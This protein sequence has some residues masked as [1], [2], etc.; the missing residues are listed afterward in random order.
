M[1]F[2]SILVPFFATVLQFSFSCAAPTP[3]E[4]GIDL[5]QRDS[6]LN[7][8]NDLN[9]VASGVASG[10]VVDNLL[11]D[12]KL[13]TATAAPTSPQQ[14]ISTLSH[15]LEA[16]PTPSNIYAF[17][18]NL[19]AAG[20]TTENVNSVVGFVDGLLTGDNSETNVDLAI[21]SIPVLPKADFRD[22]PYSQSEAQLRGAIHIP[23][24]FQYGRAGA[25]QPII[26][27]PGTGNTG[28][29]NFVGNYIPLLQNSKI[30]DPVWLN[31]PG[32]Q[33][34]DA[35]VNAE[36]VAYAINYIYGI[37]RQRKIAVL[38]WSQGGLSAQWANKYWPSTRS[39]ITDIVAFSP[40]YHGTIFAN[41]AATPDI[42]LPPAFLSQEYNSNFI[43]TLRS[44]GG[45]SA[46]VTTTTIYSGFFD[47]IVE[48]QQGTAASAYLLDARQV[49]VTNNEVQTICPGQ[50]AGS[51]YTHEGTLYNPIGY[52]LLVD[53]LSHDGPGQVSR[54]DL[55]SIC[56]QYL[57][58]GLDLSDLLLTE[59][60]ILTAAVTTLLYP[61][62][63]TVEPAIKAYAK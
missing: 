57:T 52:A 20:L 56:G 23:S 38:T 47:E 19:V 60:S 40:D 24:S 28:Y 2:V 25:P 31:I 42:P 58:S 43:K 11:E 45:D 14:A 5:Q 8:L 44:N 3:T 35:Q 48:P 16:T 51:F 1:R 33:L 55:N 4:D 54:I 9:S 30:A 13:V 29:I 22:A 41:F 7:I 34:N 61:D 26:L 21:P 53:A 27:V 59:N 62:S 39:K 63:T 37:S 50:P 17:V 32:Y 49:G 18:G 46:Y 36:Y 15:I 12:L 6:I 10:D